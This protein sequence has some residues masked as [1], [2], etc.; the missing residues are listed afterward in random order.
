MTSSFA[1]AQDAFF[2]EFFRRYP[3]H[4]TNAGNHDHDDRWPDLTDAGTAE[5]LAWL[6]VARAGFEALDGLSREEEIDRRVLVATIDE[7]RFEEEDLDEASWSAITYSYLLG[8]GLFALL[9]RQFARLEDRLTSAA[10]RIEGIPA[11]LEAARANLQSGRGRA[12]AR[13]HVEKA[14]ET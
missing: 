9:S 1:E 3:V 4:A 6:A 7:M 10:G 8:G 13:F 14:I 12:V 11:V 5:R 2:A